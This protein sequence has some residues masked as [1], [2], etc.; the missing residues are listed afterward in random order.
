M[1][2]MAHAATAARRL[3]VKLY[4]KDSST[5]AP[6]DLVP[7]L[8]RWIQERRLDELMID[9]A[10]YAHVHHGPGVLLVCH[11]ANYSFD[12]EG[13]RAGL[14]YARK[15][16]V[17][18]SPGERLALA[19]RA[20]LVAARALEEEPALAAK[21]A[22]RTDEILL[23][24]A[25]RLLAPNRADTF[26]AWKPELDA[27]AARLHG[28]APADIVHL[29][30]PKECFAARITSAPSSVA[31]LLDRLSTTPHAKPQ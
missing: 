30:D 25:D 15:R 5:V 26:A 3:Q 12:Q 1:T 28:G 14:L 21:L 6:R 27:L 19:F 20:A 22:F 29:A 4:V 31:S 10:D 11:A 13:G 8:H 18:G 23:R 17:D 7:I 24:V 2:A 9:V 16:D